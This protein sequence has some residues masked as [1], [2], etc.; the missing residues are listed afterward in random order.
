MAQLPSP[1][2]T[3]P[4]PRGPL[5]KPRSPGIAILLAVVTLGIYT[6]FWTYWTQ[7]EIKAHSGIGVGGGFG[8]LIWILVHPVTFFLIGA[9]VQSLYAM[10]QRQSPV[11]VLTGFWY[12]LPV[13][14]WI[15][16]FVK[17][18][19]ALNDYWV[20]LGAPPP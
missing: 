14:G 3:R 6:L 9:D 8:L 4:P 5:G 1:Y 2:G 19:N 11:T 18:Q 12:L 10:Q 17:V 7:E 20:G 16:W 13:I 15:V